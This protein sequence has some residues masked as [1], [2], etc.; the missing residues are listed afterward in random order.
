MVRKMAYVGISYVIGLFFASFFALSVKLSVIGFVIV[1]AAIYVIVFREKRHYVVAVAISFCLAVSVNI[2][3]TQLCYNK[4]V[5]Y[6][7]KSITFKGEVY[8]IDNSSG[9]K[10]FIYADGYI[11][12]K[13]HAKIS[14]Y[15][16]ES[17]VDYNDTIVLTGKADIPGNSIKFNTYNYL[18]SKNI[19]L[20]MLKPSSYNVIK[21]NSFCLRNSIDRYRNYINHRIMT[22]LPE[23]EGQFIAAMV[24][25]DTTYLD[26]NTL[27]NLYSCGIGHIMAVSGSHVMLIA[28]IVLLILRK[29]RQN[30][31]IQ[32]FITEGIAI[33]FCV[34]SGMSMSVV[35]A[36]V[37]LTVFL[38]G[39]LVKRNSDSL[40]SLGLA[41]I[42]ITIFNPYVVRDASFLLSFMGTFAITSFA[43]FVVK[44]FDIKGRFAEIRKL[45]VTMVCISIC[46]FPVS[47]LFFDEISIISPV[48]NILL[49]PLCVYSMVC[50]VI[51]VFTGG[52]RIIAYPLLIISGIFMKVALTISDLMSQIPFET[53]PVGYRYVPVMVILCLCFVAIISV[54][55]RTKKAFITSVIAGVFIVFTAT[56]I[57]NYFQRDKYNISILTMDKSTSVIVTNCN[58]TCVIDLGGK[59]KAAY[60]TMKYLKGK[61]IKNIDLLCLTDNEQP[62]VSSYISECYGKIRNVSVL[63]DD[64]FYIPKVNV[65]RLSKGD[66]VSVGDIN[67]NINENKKYD[68]NIG[69]FNLICYPNN[70]MINNGNSKVSLLFGY[71]NEPKTIMDNKKVL[72]FN[73]DNSKGQAYIIEAEKNGKYEIR[74][75]DNA[76]RE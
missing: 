3:Y 36:T 26:R 52:I 76:L 65:K 18:K 9:D 15:V 45:V 55:F 32:F 48:A 49:G 33:L 60:T 23:R 46:M 6:E 64:N 7:N 28:G 61:G 12:G 8:N 24:S 58:K 66:T 44:F 14:A 67:I 11:N 4:I 17:D 69:K 31:Y 29:L 68:I 47:V 16:D 38:L 51:V 41:G 57:N 39:I 10:Q 2:L 56:G 74:R 27:N 42:V 71:N 19:Y 22:I 21:D 20:Q 62:A 25:G 37:M 59:G 73:K 75:M 1:S 13:T 35:R 53:L 30:R 72:Y 50:G 54:F 40:S 70:D 43:P 34:F 5:D 63:E